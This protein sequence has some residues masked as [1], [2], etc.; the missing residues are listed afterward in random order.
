MLFTIL[1]EEDINLLVLWLNKYPIFYKLITLLCIGGSQIET[2]VEEG[3]WKGRIWDCQNPRLKGCDF[4]GPC[5][6]S[7]WAKCIGKE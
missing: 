1:F 6:H 3:S 5:R 2:F 4:D 7:Q